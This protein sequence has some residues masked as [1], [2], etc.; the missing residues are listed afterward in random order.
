MIHPSLLLIPGPVFWTL[1]A[2]W[3]LASFLEYVVRR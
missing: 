2:G 1:Y 3:L